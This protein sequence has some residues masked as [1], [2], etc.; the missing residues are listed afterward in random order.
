ML[1]NDQSKENK[2]AKFIF[3]NNKILILSFSLIISEFYFFNINARVLVSF[4]YIIFN[5]LTLFFFLIIL[6]YFLFKLFK[7]NYFL[8]SEK[9]SY[10]FFTVILTFILFKIIQI[11]SFYGNFLNIK[12]LVQTILIN[13]FQNKFHFYIH[14]LKILIPFSLIY[15]LVF[16]YFKSKKLY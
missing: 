9:K 8:I 7:L 11:P 3:D 16:K 12:E 2:V 4:G 15:L 10:F 13:I 6:F 1:V 14:F 5:T